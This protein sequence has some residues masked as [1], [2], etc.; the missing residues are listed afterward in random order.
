M[1]EYTLMEKLIF[2]PEFIR[3]EECRN[4]AKPTIQTMP[5]LNAKFCF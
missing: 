2:M 3:K 1:E 4:A 5:G